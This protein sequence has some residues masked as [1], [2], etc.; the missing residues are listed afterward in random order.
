[1]E[2]SEGATDDTCRESHERGLYR[3]IACN[4]L[5]LDKGKGILS[6]F[7]EVEVLLKMDTELI[8]GNSS[9]IYCL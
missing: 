5:A 9:M 8:E 4:Q 2:R 1:M 6:L 3:L 7:D